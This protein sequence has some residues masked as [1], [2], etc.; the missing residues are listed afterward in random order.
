[1]KNNKIASE[2]PAKDTCD[3][4]RYVVFYA[5]TLGQYDYDEDEEDETYIPSAQERL[6]KAILERRYPVRRKLY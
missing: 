6:T 4:L 3:A 2:D 1:M 5:A